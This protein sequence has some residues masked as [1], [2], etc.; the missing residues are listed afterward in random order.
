[1]ENN[2][3]SDYFEGAQKKPFALYIDSMASSFG[4]YS[5]EQGMQFLFGWIPTFIGIGIRSLVYRVL[6]DKRSSDSI[7]AEPNVDIRYFNNIACGK[8]VYV[9]RNVRIHGSIAGIE[10]GDY[11]RVMFGSYLCS[12][13]SDMVPGEGLHIGKNCWIG[14]NNVLHGGRGGIWIG[15]NT[16][17]APQVVLVC[18]NHVLQRDEN[19]RD[20]YDQQPIVIGNN[21]WLGAG[22]TI[23]GGVKLGNNVTVAAGA[24]VNDSFGDNVLIGGT[25]ARVLKNL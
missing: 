7:Y 3:L 10:I 14:I 15:D 1:M 18:G 9:D 25:P 13:T 16:L 24:V 11:T 4:R 5:L 8:K 23:L 21:C 20:S 19:N 6:L 22:C 2:K 12:Y 17:L